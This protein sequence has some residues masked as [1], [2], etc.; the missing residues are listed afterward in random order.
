[1]E[2]AVTERR[3]GGRPRKGEPVIDRKKIVQTAWA[4]VDEHGL[5]GLSTRTLA[6]A[7]EVKSPAI[8]W[9]IGSKEELFSLMIEDLLQDSISDCDGPDWQEWFIKVGQRQRQLLLSHRDA[10]I[11]AS[12][13]PPTERIRNELFPRLFKPLVDGGMDLA[14]ASAAA[15]GLASLVLGWVIYEQR[16]ATH[17]MMEAYHDPDSAFDS[18]LTAFV[19]GLAQR[20]E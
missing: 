17:A 19:S 7:L 6:A 2:L 12:I 18:A 15:G 1:M 4:I 20:L 13:A 10:S 11:I 8:Y 3:K 14:E 9:H 5:A 16:P